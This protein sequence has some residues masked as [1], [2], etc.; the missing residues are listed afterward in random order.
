MA[1][2]AAAGELLC[3]AATLTTNKT[4]EII[5]RVQRCSSLSL[6]RWH[7]SHLYLEAVGYLKLGEEG[8]SVAGQCK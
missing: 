6:R 2:S 5:L 1:I 4:V 7:K 8:L 3:N